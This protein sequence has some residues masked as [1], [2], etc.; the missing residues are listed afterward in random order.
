MHLPL[1]VLMARQRSWLFASL[2]LALLLSACAHVAGYAG[3][4]PANI[5]CKGKA[6]ITG[7]GAATVGAGIGGSEM[8]G[9]TLQADCGDGFSYTQGSAAT[10]A[11]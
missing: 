11:Q 5:T 3:S 7:S 1:L 8:N 10:P 4:H 2:G 9:F 6:A